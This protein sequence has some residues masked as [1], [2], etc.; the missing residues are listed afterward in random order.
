MELI[1]QTQMMALRRKNLFR[2]KE[3]LVHHISK[4]QE[5]GVLLFFYLLFSGVG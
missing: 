4:A 1:P 3:P 5:W 2:E